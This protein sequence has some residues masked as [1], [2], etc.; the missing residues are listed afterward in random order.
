MALATATALTLGP[1]AVG[2]LTSHVARKMTGVREGEVEQAAKKMARRAD[3]EKAVV[4]QKL[5]TGVYDQPQ[6]NL[7]SL[8]ALAM[9]AGVGKR[10][11]T[12]RELVGSQYADSVSDQLAQHLGFNDRKHLMKRTADMDAPSLSRLLQ[13]KAG[14]R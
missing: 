14:S 8:E 4:A 9:A 3:L 5:Q 1:L 7:T 12:V 6:E 13:R 11:M 10:D 2:A